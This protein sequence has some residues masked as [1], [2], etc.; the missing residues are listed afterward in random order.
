[1]SP[2][3]KSTTKRTVRWEELKSNRFSESVS[4]ESDS[5]QSWPGTPS[6]RQKSTI[7]PNIEFISPFPLLAVFL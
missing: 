5:S 6:S 4:S 7:R 2:R 1:M 3:V